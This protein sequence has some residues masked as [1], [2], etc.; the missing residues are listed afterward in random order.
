MI[1]SG[2]FL[3]TTEAAKYFTYMRDDRY[4]PFPSMM[5][6]LCEP[7]PEKETRD[8]FYEIVPD[9]VRPRFALNR[10]RS[11]YRYYSRGDL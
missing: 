3:N 10:A 5:T 7:I 9:D 11:I 8:L 4:T 6:V 2:R 1:F